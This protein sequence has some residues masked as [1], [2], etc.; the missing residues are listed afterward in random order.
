MTDPAPPRERLLTTR[1]SMGLRE[2]RL[3]VDSGLLV[4]SYL[5]SVP[6]SHYEGKAV[7]PGCRD[8]ASV[9]F[10]LG[11]N[12]PQS[13]IQRQQT[14]AFQMPG[15]AMGNRVAELIRFASLLVRALPQRNLADDS[16]QHAWQSI[17]YSESSLPASQDVLHSRRRTSGS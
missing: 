16:E 17:G 15:Q 1:K 12:R 5:E 3:R 6:R 9:E 4:K 14:L 8:Q 7:V 10:L 2:C 13:D 11:R